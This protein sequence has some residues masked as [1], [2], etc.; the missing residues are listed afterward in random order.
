MLRQLLSEY[1]ERFSC[2]VGNLVSCGSVLNW[3]E[4]DNRGNR[5]LVTDESAINTPAVA[6]A[7]VTRSY[8]AQAPDEISFQVGGTT[9][10][11]SSAFFP[12]SAESS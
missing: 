9:C 8:Q 5:L 2:L 12:R 10:P 4:L 11:Y 7:Y 1:L 6:A 3:L